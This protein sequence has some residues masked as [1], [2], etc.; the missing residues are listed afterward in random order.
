[1]AQHALAQHALADY[2]TE[3]EISQARGAAALARVTG[4]R[5]S[6]ERREYRNAEGR[7][8]TASEIAVEAIEVN[9]HWGP[10]Y[11]VTTHNSMVIVLA[12]SPGRHASHAIDDLAQALLDENVEEQAE[13][14]EYDEDYFRAEEV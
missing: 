1:M 14:H 3:D 12:S 4:S 5:G 6:T 9:R 11:R 10:A 7:L 8:V 2:F 13:L